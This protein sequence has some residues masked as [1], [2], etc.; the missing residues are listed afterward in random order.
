MG[1]SAVERHTQGTRWTL[2]LHSA[3]RSNVDGAA[4]R[5]RW[6]SRGNTTRDMARTGGAI[7][8]AGNTA[9]RDRLMGEFHNLASRNHWVVWS[10]YG[11]LTARTP[12]ESAHDG[13]RGGTE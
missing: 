4:N 1:A 8:I 6:L 12:T 2:R 11:D 7:A 9:E 5:A 3:T 13:R 10:V